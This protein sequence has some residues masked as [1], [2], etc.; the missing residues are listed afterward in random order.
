MNRPQVAYFLSGPLVYF[1]SGA[2][3]ERQLQRD[4]DRPV[5]SQWPFSI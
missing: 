2:R 4:H 1:P 5:I 3:T